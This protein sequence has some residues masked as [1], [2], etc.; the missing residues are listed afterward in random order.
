[1][2]LPSMNSSQVMAKATHEHGTPDHAFVMHHGESDNPVLVLVFGEHDL[3]KHFDFIEDHADFALVDVGVLDVAQGFY[4]QVGVD[5]IRG[6]RAG[7]V[8]EPPGLVHVHLDEKGLFL[9]P[10]KK[11]IINHTHQ[12]INF[13]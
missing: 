3:G 10:H 12:I 8:F 4:D 5:H 6:V 7:G 9:S 11:R 1:M 2:G 13:L